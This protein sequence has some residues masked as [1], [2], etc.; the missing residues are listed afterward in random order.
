[1]QPKLGTM[2]DL[3]DG[4]TVV[5]VLH[6]LQVNSKRYMTVPQIHK[7]TVDT[8]ASGLT[9][10]QVRDAMKLSPTVGAPEAG[11]VD[12]HLDDIWQTRTKHRVSCLPIISWVVPTNRIKMT[13]LILSSRQS[14]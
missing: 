7:S 13:K 11:S 5:E 8:G 2:V 1:M 4:A 14:H 12:E 3:S 9:Q 10:Q 6:R